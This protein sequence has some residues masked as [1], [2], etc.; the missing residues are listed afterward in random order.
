MANLVT[1]KVDWQPSKD[2][3]WKKDKCRSKMLAD[4]N[5]GHTAVNIG[6]CVAAF[7]IWLQI[8]IKKI[9]NLDDHILYQG[10]PFSRFHESIHKFQSILGTTPQ[11]K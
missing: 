8:Q 3:E 5:D 11:T 9:Q 6:L 1:V 4:K 2:L 10:L 7:K